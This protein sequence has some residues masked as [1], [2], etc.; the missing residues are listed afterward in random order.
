MELQDVMNL[1]VPAAIAGIGFLTRQAVTA[2]QELSKTTELQKGMQRDMDRLSSE[3]IVNRNG[4]AELAT[5]IARLSA[6][7]EMV[8][9]L[10]EQVRM[11]MR[12]K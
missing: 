7:T 3:M 11:E 8:V 6:Q 4:Y 2:S 10:I 1:L 5:A 12:Q 9:T